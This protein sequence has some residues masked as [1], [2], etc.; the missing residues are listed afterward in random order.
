MQKQNVNILRLC[1]FEQMGGVAKTTEI[2]EMLFGF[3]ISLLKHKSFFAV[4]SLRS[5]MALRL[6]QNKTSTAE[7]G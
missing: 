4:L 2:W 1:S 5:L 6:T 3:C 7:L